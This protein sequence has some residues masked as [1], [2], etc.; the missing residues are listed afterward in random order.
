M[1]S[2]SPIVHLLIHSV[3]G[4]FLSPRLYSY[5]VKIIIQQPLGDVEKTLKFLKKGNRQSRLTATATISR[6]E[7]YAG[8]KVLFFG[9]LLL[10][11]KIR[12]KI[13][14]SN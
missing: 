7:L 10:K 8:E 5:L 1:V 13:K 14:I 4:P 2:I 12:L 9:T 3:V 11:K 6:I